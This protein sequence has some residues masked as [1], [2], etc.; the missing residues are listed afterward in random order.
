MCDLAFGECSGVVLSYKSTNARH[1]ESRPVSGWH[2]V[3][4]AHL[5]EPVHRSPGPLAGIP[6]LV[7]L[8]RIGL[9]T[10]NGRQQCRELGIRNNLGNLSAVGSS[11]RRF[12]RS[13]TRRAAVQASHWP[14]RQLPTGSAAGDIA[15]LLF[16]PVYETGMAVGNLRMRRVSGH[17]SWQGSEPSAEP[18][19][20]KGINIGG[21][22]PSTR[23]VCVF[24]LVAP[25]CRLEVTRLLRQQSPLCLF[26]RVYPATTAFSPSPAQKLPSITNSPSSL[27]L[28]A[29]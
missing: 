18:V 14:W 19:E 26:L 17:S 20:S 13:R 3:G 25:L 6:H 10:S 5:A 7:P 29:V 16:C 9:Y 8:L 22:A 11:A 4:L 2:A 12:S 27:V 1:G 15:S 21:P 24:Y 23:P 28:R